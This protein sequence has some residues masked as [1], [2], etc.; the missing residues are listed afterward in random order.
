MV[1]DMLIDD[2]KEFSVDARIQVFS[3]FEVFLPCCE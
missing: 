3:K 2:F 1:G